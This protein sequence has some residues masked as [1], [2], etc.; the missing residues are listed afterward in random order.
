MH[1]LSA[2]RTE[3][4]NPLSFAL[5]TL[6]DK[7]EREPNNA[8]SVAQSVKLPLVIN[9]RIE[10]PGDSDV[11]RFTG[12]SN[13]AI[14]AEV[15]A[16]RL[17][18]PLDSF[19]KLTDESGKVIAFSDD[20]EEISAGLNTH[21]ADSWLMAKLPAD[22]DYFVHIS[23]TAR[24]GGEEYGYRLRIS[25]PQPDFDLRVVPSSIGLRTN[26]SASVTVYA[27]RKD[28]F[29]R[30]ITLTL[31]DPP[32]GFSA[33]PVKLSAGQT[34]ARLVIR[35]PSAPTKQPVN[36]TV[37]GT[38]PVGE[39]QIVREAVAA[40]D[41]MQAFLW[42]QLVPANEFK[43]LVFDPGYEPP[44]KRRVP[45]RPAPTFSATNVVVVAT[46]APA[47]TNAVASAKPKFTKNQV[48]RRL[49]ELKLLYEEGLL[50]DAF[51]NA[52]ADECEAMQ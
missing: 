20:R 5:D 42:R 48:A 6:P 7:L 38:G 12:R 3:I 43:A 49:R 47:G 19:I 2:T 28:G 4:F 31:K 46:N 41:R 14:V 21:H 15:T 9:G 35:G 26:S 8:L 45:D 27:Q 29:A 17:D 40:E 34:S 25:P 22:G 32:P 33:E 1:S 10:K 11:F 13:E 24:K 51:Y 16:R 37:I 18:S 44:P 39:K 52:K 23:D 36:L 50:T 30:S